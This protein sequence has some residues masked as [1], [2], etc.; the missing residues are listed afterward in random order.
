MWV[1]ATPFFWLLARLTYQM[2]KA[3]ETSGCEVRPL[4]RGPCQVLE[5]LLP[6][7]D[8]ALWVQALKFQEEGPVGR[9]HPADPV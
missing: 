8:R 5:M 3:K 2:C 4:Q 6:F 9:I 7:G 1:V